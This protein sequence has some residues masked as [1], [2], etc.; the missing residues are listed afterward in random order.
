MKEP[1]ALFAKEYKSRNPNVDCFTSLSGPYN[2]M[3]IIDLRCKVGTDYI[4]CPHKLY[5]EMNT[6]VTNWTS[7]LNFCK[8]PPRP[9][10]PPRA[11]MHV[12]VI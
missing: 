3:C 4:K 9:L 12:S 11:M 8:L 7:L 5:L 10:P 6:T 1:Q 2:G